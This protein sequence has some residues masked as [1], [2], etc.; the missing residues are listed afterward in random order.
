LGQRFCTT[1]PVECT[2]PEALF[3]L[4][5]RTI[6]PDDTLKVLVFVTVNTGKTSGTLKN[7]ATVSEEE[8]LNASATSENQ[9]SEEVPSFGASQLLSTISG[10]D[11]APDI[12]AGDHPYELTTRIDMR[13]AI[14]LGPESVARLTRSVRDVKDV[15]VDLPLGFIG[16]AL[17]APKCTFA[18]L[19]TVAGCPPS[20]QV[21][22]IQSEP[23]G[24]ASV[25]GG[26]Y[27]MVP[28]RGVAAEF[29]YVDALF[30]SH[31]IYASVVPTSVGYVLRATSREVPQVALTD[32]IA[33][34]YGDPATKD[35]AGGAPAAMFT[36][37]SNCSGQ[38][39]RTT[40][41]MD[42]WQDPGSFNS[43]GT[44]NVAGAGWVSSS[45][46][47]PPVTG[48]NALRFEP[49]AFFARPETSTADSP[50]GLNFELKVPQS[51]APGTLATA[52]LR[53]ASVKLPP[54][55]TID[56]SAASGL[57]ACSI[58]QIGWLGGSPSD[59]TPDAPSCPEASKIGSVE[60]TSPLLEGT[61]MGSIY[62]ATQNQNPFNS[63]F[64]GYIVVDDP[65]TGVVVKIAGNL[66]PNQQTGQITGVF[67]ENP[68]LPFSDLKLHFFGGPRGDLATPNACT[69]YTTSADLSPWSAP[70]SGPDAFP[71]DSFAIDNGCVSGLAPSFSAGTVT[72]NAGS[73]SPFTLSFGRQDSEEELAGLSV[74]LPPGL[75]GKLAGLGE[76]SD[77][78]LAAAAGKSGGAEQASPSCPASSRLGS[79]LTATGPGPTPYYVSG[80]AYLTGP[81]KSGPYG[82][83]VVVP[84]LAGPF[85]LG[86]VVIRQ[87]LYIDP[88]DAHVTDVSDPF[89]T[90]LDGVPLR[91]K[92][93]Q[94]TLDR[95]G[96]TFNPTN[97][98]PLTLSGTVLGVG[99]AA[100]PVASR[101]QA[102][103][104]SAL[105]FKPGFSASTAGKASK[106]SGASLD[107][108]VSSK[109]GPDAS[110]EEANIRSVKVDLPKQLPSRLT[111]LQKACLA[112]VFEANP[113]SCP[114]ES[115]VGTATAVTPVLANPLTGPAYLVSHGNEA[116]P[117][118]EI[119][120]QGE[121]ITLILDGNTKI[122]KGITSS[123][124]KTVPD[125]PI[126]SFELKLP[127]GPFSV[128]AVNLPQKAKYNFCGQAALS[129][130]TLITAQNG[131]VLKQTT[132]IAVTG[133]P[134][135]K[136]KAKKKATKKPKHG[137]KAKHSSHKASRRR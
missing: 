41:Y 62:L 43:D 33:T 57:Q 105:K 128:L 102:A 58:A 120:L 28:E 129:M 109:G 27:N 112:K 83:A 125:A 113:A 91:I 101:F 118:L 63:L 134:K 95:P 122:T 35:K 100:A 52:P 97:C 53:N 12:Q 30:N 119:V 70:D 111:T 136:K 4:G 14:G 133:C 94:V 23:K 40:V 15:V 76:C 123:F 104:C 25:N 88:T 69:T 59:F 135:A 78:A 115:D 64:A 124:F 127:S 9:I 82:V 110:G 73:Y 3:T 65:T 5:E 36:N 26:L 37:P 87:A 22:H 48:C 132:K 34:F 8:G 90:I 2:I 77:A 60:L 72:P 1:T 16:G 32:I 46:E 86:T 130:P 20:T 107:V 79:V 31:V 7:T 137:K 67:D 114:K 13:T 89:P 21:G 75:L 50:T 81:Y 19:I 6:L 51:E 45:A 42:S 80:N 99:G 93:V 39:L 29:G 103:N 96:F 55:L 10:L 38:P 61:L 116:F 106:A 24:S 85:D 131:A 74:S 11:G 71:S 47:T 84:A 108:K 17:A 66:T 98:N 54:G 126:K 18:Q 44:P 117:D 56:P 68:Q 92:H 121:G 49:T